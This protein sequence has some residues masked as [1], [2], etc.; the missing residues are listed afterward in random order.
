MIGE[1]LEL[2]PHQILPEVPDRPNDC[3]ELLVVGRPSPFGFAQDTA[4]VRDDSLLA[5]TVSDSTEP[6]AEL[7]ASVASVN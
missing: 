2:R 3:P 4:G 7:D 1:D 6:T 5:A